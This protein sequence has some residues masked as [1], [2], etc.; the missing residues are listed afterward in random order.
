MV[1]F[2]E[3]ALDGQEFHEAILQCPGERLQRAD[4]CQRAG[5]LPGD[6]RFCAIGVE[7]IAGPRDVRPADRCVS[8]SRPASRACTASRRNARLLRKMRRGLRL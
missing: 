3:R 8:P 7:V 6:L 2:S 5:W 1:Q 4:T